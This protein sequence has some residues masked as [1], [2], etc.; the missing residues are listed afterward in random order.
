MQTLDYEATTAAAALRPAVPAFRAGDV[1]DIQ[2]AVPDN[3]DRV[4]T[5]RGL[6][7]ARYNKGI[8]SSVVLRS[9]IHDHAVERSFP[10]YGPQLRSITL[11]ERRHAARAKLFFLRRKPLRDSRVSGGGVV[12][13]GAA[14]NATRG[15]SGA[16]GEPKPGGG[17]K[18]GGGS[19]SKKGGR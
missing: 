3:K 14:G 15:A 18:G 8:S 13:Q 6:V 11:V 19:T 5:F 12:S 16:A 7:I 2:V 10:L 1:L 9:V 17:K 4:T